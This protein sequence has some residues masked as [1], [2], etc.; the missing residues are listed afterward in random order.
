MQQEVLFEH[1][2]ALY[3]EHRHQD[4]AHII[5]QLKE[6]GGG[7]GE[8]KSDLLHLELQLLYRTE[9]YNE[10]PTVCSDIISHLY[11]DDP[12]ISEILTNLNAVKV[13]APSLMP[14]RF[15]SWI[16]PK[17]TKQLTTVPASDGCSEETITK[18]LTGI[19]T[20]LAYVYQKLGRVAEAEQLYLSIL[21]QKLSD[22]A[23]M[24][25]ASNNLV[26]IRG[27]KDLFDS[28]KRY[29]STVA[30][31]L[32]K[33]LTTAQRKTIALN[34]CVL[35]LLMKKF[36][37]CKDQLQTF[38]T[39]FGPDPTHHLLHAT[40]LHQTVS[41]QT[42]ISYLTTHITST[43]SSIPLVLAVVELYLG[44]GDVEAAVET[45]ER[46]VEG[47]GWV[48][49]LVG[50]LAG[51]W[52]VGRREEKAVEVVGRAVEAWKLEN[53][54]SSLLRQAATFKLSTHQYRSAAQ[55]FEGIVKR[56][57]GDVEALAGLV[58]A[59]VEVDVDVAERVPTP[60]KKLKKRKPKTT[61]VFD[62]SI[63]PDPERWLPNGSGRRLRRRWE[64]GAFEGDAGGGGGG[65]WEGVG[66]GGDVEMKEVGGAGLGSGVG[67]GLG[68]GVGAGLGSGVGAGLGS[69]VGAG[70]GS[71][72]GAGLGSGG[73]SGKVKGKKRK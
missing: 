1:A 55:D 30:K 62:R 40:L 27:H 33:K 36:P 44:V 63:I 17:P 14:S 13:F 65:G 72:G 15:R 21:N 64:E 66:V 60:Q 23:V 25:I 56:D 50:V 34:G 8:R 9:Q 31:G 20:Q 11:K 54:P 37:L 24:A 71:G 57:D 70:L 35:S 59:F 12:Y 16:P 28:V 32:D 4:C 22:S 19:V 68:S 67:A 39:T 41:P 69:G 47:V 58:R 49:A 73:G 18:E 29:R 6:W 7:G 52:R 38:L 43:P 3:R 10:T 45:L 2:Y 61:K 5:K 51:L 48:P 53:A 42:A 26:A 46:F